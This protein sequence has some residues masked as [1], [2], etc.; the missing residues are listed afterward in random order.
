MGQITRGEEKRG[1]ERFG[2]LGEIGCLYKTACGAAFL[3]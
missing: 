3:F 1:G 2:V